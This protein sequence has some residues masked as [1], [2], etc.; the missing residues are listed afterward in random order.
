MTRPP[1]DT[2]GRCPYHPTATLNGENGRFAC[3][4]CGR[5]LTPGVDTPPT[6]P[7]SE[8][9]LAFWLGEMVCDDVDACDVDPRDTRILN[10]TKN[11]RDF[12]VMVREA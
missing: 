7:M 6:K 8:R 4:T 3:S 9:D 10:L 11:G 1:S 2:I 12:V 5:F